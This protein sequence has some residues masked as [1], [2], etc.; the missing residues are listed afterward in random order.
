MKLQWINIF[1]K[2]DDFTWKIYDE[3][4]FYFKSKY[5]GIK[6][7]GKKEL[8]YALKDRLEENHY[9]LD[10]FA[11]CVEFYPKRDRFT[12][13]TP[14]GKNFADYGLCYNKYTESVTYYELTV[15]YGENF[16]EEIEM[17]LTSMNM[18]VL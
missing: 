18:G 7:V 2:Y 8:K 9:F 5:P 6:C 17:L 13:Y 14:I 15:D 4:E 12:V 16:K 3:V 1:I 11:F 10:I